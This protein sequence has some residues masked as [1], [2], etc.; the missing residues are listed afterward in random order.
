MEN[1]VGVLKGTDK[2][3]CFRELLELTNFSDVLLQAYRTSEKDIADYRIVIKP[4]M[5]V[6]IS[7][8]GFEATVTDKDLVEHL[9]DELIEMGF[10]N[11]SLCEAQNDV[12]RMLK[13]HN[14]R[15]VAEQ[16]GY[17]PR[18]R[19]KIVDLTLESIPFRYSY[20]SDDGKLRTW[21]DRVGKTWKDADFRVTFAKCKTHEHDWMTLGVKNIYGC[22]PSAN[23]VAKYHIRN[24]VFD[25]TARSLRNFP[26][27]FSFIDG[28]IGSDGFQGYK[29]PRPKELRMLFGGKDAIAVDMEV[30]KRANL[31][32]LK[33]RI[34]YEAVK[35]L[36]EGQY[37]QYRVLG[38]ET[39]FFVDL[40]NWENI[41]DEIVSSIDL[42][43]EVYI[44]WAFINL[45]PSTEI[46]YDLFPPKNILFRFLVWTSK[47]LYS[48]FKYSR[49]FKKLYGSRS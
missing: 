6:F 7:S 37:P 25:V 9:V 11:I 48:I 41:S 16:I 17:R 29:M 3:S 15:F 28:W 21:R 23:K 31:D 20:M 19:Y 38:N 32:P 34:L 5:M 49:L 46:D 27:H 10:S 22:F 36:N 13:N 45:R 44:S 33:S 12:G 2:I 26:L 35:Q 39:T 47:K 30:F 8:D 40:C 14:V 42:I 1:V 43:E 18:G 24:E 4:N